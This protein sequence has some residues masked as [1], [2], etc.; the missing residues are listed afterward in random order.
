MTTVAST[1][2]LQNAKPLRSHVTMDRADCPWFSTKDAALAKAPRNA[3]IPSQDR[4]RM[5]LRFH[6]LREVHASIDM[7]SKTVGEGCFC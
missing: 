4:R 6:E 5:K 3:A 1:G 2:N 7:Y